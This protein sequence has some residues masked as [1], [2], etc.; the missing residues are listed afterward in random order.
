MA[1]AFATARETATVAF[2]PNL[3]LLG[4]PSAEIMA[5]SIALRF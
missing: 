4:V 3:L 5:L 2:A 1:P